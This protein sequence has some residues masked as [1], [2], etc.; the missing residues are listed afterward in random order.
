MNSSFYV[1]TFYALYYL[2]LEPF[3][4]I[5]YLPFLYSLVYLANVFVNTFHDNANIYALYL[6]I[7][8][9]T[10][11]I[12]GH[13]IF[14]KRAP[15]FLDSALQAFLLAPLFIWLE[16]LFSFGYRPQLKLRLEKKAEEAIREWKKTKK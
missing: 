7:F 15:A 5:F 11:Q 8:S 9:W 16:L 1:V 4:T 13:Q 6:H 3:A 14:E 12:L 2:L 10:A